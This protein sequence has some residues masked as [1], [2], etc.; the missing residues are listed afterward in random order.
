MTF[1]KIENLVN[2]ITSTDEEVEA[3]RAVIHE[4]KWRAS[5]EA[6]C[7]GESLGN[8]LEDIVQICEI[9]GVK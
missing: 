4:I 8:R 6:Y 2:G 3:L 1:D 7:N 5:G 9:T